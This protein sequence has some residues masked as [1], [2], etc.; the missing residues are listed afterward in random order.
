MEKI[1]AQ[2][3][4]RNGKTINSPSNFSNNG[5]TPNEL[6]AKLSDTYYRELNQYPNSENRYTIGFGPF[7]A[8]TETIA[9]CALVWCFRSIAT[10]INLLTTLGEFGQAWIG[11]IDP[12]K[13]LEKELGKQKT[14]GKSQEIV[15]D[16][17]MKRK[18]L[19]ESIAAK[20]SGMAWFQLFAGGG[21]V[22]GMM[23]EYLTGKNEGNITEVPFFK[24]VILSAS[25]AMNVFFMLAGAQEKSFL[26][27]L[28]WNGGGKGGKGQDYRSM[29]INGD[30]DMRGA[31]E[32]G[33]MTIVPWI[34][35]VSFIKQFV[36]AAVV[37]GAMREGL[38]YF[39]ESENMNLTVGKKKL[40]AIDLNKK[41]VISKLIKFF[42]NPFSFV[43]KDKSSDDEG[44]RYRLCWPFNKALGFL[45]G[46]ENDVGGPGSSGF[47]NKFIAPLLKN[48]FGCN[49][50]NAYLDND[51]NIICEFIEELEPEAAVTKHT[52]NQ[53]LRDDESLIDISD[54]NPIRPRTIA[55]A[56]N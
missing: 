29:I 8:I 52:R 16:D 30:S 33:I 35:N 15:L 41:P 38:E 24:K 4:N 56:A 18:K 43:L 51:K 32:W 12:N 47:R 22:L 53:A 54:R 1:A 49:P 10:G 5:L 40:I 37:Y 45:L 28:S 39:A 19:E 3:F 50:F 34:S 31:I 9:A 14:G 25:S 44:A 55:A 23:W 13:V 27:M 48:I 20:E 7:V 26:S 36:D 42:V 2:T 17:L 21:G 11:G 6:T 46:F